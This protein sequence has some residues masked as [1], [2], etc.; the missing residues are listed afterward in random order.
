[1]DILEV[2]SNKGAEE[3][4][5]LLAVASI[6]QKY[7]LKIRSILSSLGAY[8][9][10][11][12]KADTRLKE[13]S[14]MVIRECLVC[15]GLWVLFFF[16]GGVSLFFFF[17]VLFSS[18]LT[19]QLASKLL[20]VWWM[21]IFN[22]WESEASVIH[23]WGRADVTQSMSLLWSVFMTLPQGLPVAVEIWLFAIYYNFWQIIIFHSRNMSYSTWLD[24]PATKLES[25]LQIPE[26]TRN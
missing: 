15:R 2:S 20:P 9:V 18:T 22:A 4:M 11:A 19:E 21:V 1:M 6:Y 17:I 16:W 25:S 24:L 5:L 8:A 7:C 12:G 10:A 26:L 3:W 14:T 13:P 23:R